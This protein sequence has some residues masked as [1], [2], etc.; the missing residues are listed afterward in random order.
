MLGVA[1]G[2]K[3]TENRGQG[4]G[5]RGQESGKSGISHLSSLI[6][7]LKSNISH[8]ASIIGGTILYLGILSLIVAGFRFSVFG[9]RWGESIF[10]LLPIIGGLLTGCAWTFANRELIQ[11]GETAG[12]SSGLLNGVDLFGSCVGSFFISVFFVPIYGFHFSLLLLAC[13]NLVALCF[14]LKKHG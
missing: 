2:A 6:W 14:L 9:S 1:F 12:R 3:W 7:H 10:Y 13:L 4:L 8:L 11:K 5:D